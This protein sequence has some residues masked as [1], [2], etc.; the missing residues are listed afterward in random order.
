MF[1]KLL[2]FALLGT[3]LSSVFMS[4]DVNETFTVAEEYGTRSANIEDYADYPAEY[5]Y[6]QENFDMH[7]GGFASY[8]YK[9]TSAPK[10]YEAYIGTYLFYN[11]TRRDGR[12]VNAAFPFANKE[13]IEEDLNS[14]NF[15]VFTL[16][17]DGKQYLGLRTYPPK[18]DMPKVISTTAYDK[19]GQAIS[20]ENTDELSKIDYVDLK[21]DRAM[22]TSY[23]LVG[24]NN[25]AT[26][27]YKNGK[28][29]NDRIF[30]IELSIINE[31]PYHYVLNYTWDKSVKNSGFRDANGILLDEFNFG[32]TGTSAMQ[33]PNTF[34]LEIPASNVTF[35]PNE[36]EENGITKK[37][38]QAIVNVTE[39]LNHEIVKTG[40]T[41]VLKYKL[42]SMDDLPAIKANIVDP[43]Y[44]EDTKSYWTVISDSYDQVFVNELKAGELEPNYYT[45]ELTFPITD[46]MHSSQLVIQLW[47]D[48]E[49]TVVLPTIEFVK[50]E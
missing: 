29:I 28:W 20:F 49:T 48:S 50:V 3:L 8:W 5:D 19:K 45:G 7:W 14:G 43:N 6:L 44:N 4:C 42:S 37:N 12:Y 11:Y 39:L 46:R 31:V 13:K 30:R 41:V 40:D 22:N 38:L 1:K 27:A 26:G 33:H 24:W 18:K 2:T 47:C 23:W 10:E 15:E 35:E 25:A 17:N 34:I 9:I 32:F 36:W 16:N 21:F